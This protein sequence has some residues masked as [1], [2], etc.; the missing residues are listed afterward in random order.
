MDKSKLSNTART[1]VAQEK[2]ILAA[3][4][5]TGTIQKRLGSVGVDSTPETN[6]K[7]RQLLFT[8]PEIEKY[9]SGVIMFDETIRQI[10]D[11]GVGFVDYLK[12]KGIVTGIKVDKGK[13]EAPN[14]PGEFITEGLDGLRIR[15][16]EYKDMGAEFAK[17]RAVVNISKST[18]NKIVIN[19]N[20]QKMAIYASCC[21]EIGLVPVVEPEVLM[22]GDHTAAK[23]GDV[24]KK[25]LEALWSY[26]FDHKVYLEGTILKINMIVPGKTSKRKLSVAEIASKTTKIMKEAVSVAIPGIVFLSGGL[27]EIDATSYLNQMNKQKDLPWELSFSFGRALQQSALKAWSGKD[28]NIEAAQNVFL[29][30]AKMNSLARSGDYKKENEI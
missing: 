16:K 13:A 17:W 25:T 22:D 8:T 5:S 18:P 19:S 15:L 30:R 6:R 29:H 28:E 26:L 1:L 12:E 14:F 7:Y 24:T 4:E 27:S 9:I 2:G 11:D 3:D 10:T 23:C 20:M 21:Q